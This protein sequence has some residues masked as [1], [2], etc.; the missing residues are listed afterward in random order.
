MFRGTEIPKLNRWSMELADYKITFVLIKGKNNVLADTVSRLQMLNIY[1]EPQENP[2][3]QVV[4]NS[5]EVVTEI[6]ATNMHNI[7]ASMLHNEQKLDKT[8]KN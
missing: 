1:E 3:A 8:G 6:C 2:K 5:Q 7:S 4:N